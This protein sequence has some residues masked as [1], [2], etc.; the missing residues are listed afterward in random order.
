MEIA[1]VGDVRLARDLT[2]TASWP[3]LD[4]K[5]EEARDRKMNPAGVHIHQ[6]NWQNCISFTRAAERGS[7]TFPSGG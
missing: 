6:P 1:S 3:F 4:P 5:I 2:C 7:Q